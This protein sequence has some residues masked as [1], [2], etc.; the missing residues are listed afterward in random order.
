MLQ[1]GP[2]PED[3]ERYMT[4]LSSARRKLFAESMNGLSASQLETFWGVYSEY[5][6]DKNALA[7]ARVELLKKS[8]GEPARP[9]E[10]R[11]RT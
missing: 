4:A 7:V 9:R 1:H 5:E 2:S 11:T 8:R 10:S 3:Q 6:K